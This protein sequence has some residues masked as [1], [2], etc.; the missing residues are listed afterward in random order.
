MRRMSFPFYRQQNLPVTITKTGESSSC[1]ASQAGG[2]RFCNERLDLAFGN[3][4][5]RQLLLL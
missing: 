3:P 4:N 1:T 2:A 5:N